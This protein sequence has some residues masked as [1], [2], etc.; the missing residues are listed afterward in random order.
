MISETGRRGSAA[1]IAT[2][3]TKENRSYLGS[4]LA[5]V[6]LLDL[7]PGLGVGGVIAL[8]PLE[9]VTASALL[10]ETHEGALKSLTGGRGDLVDL[11]VLH[12]VR[13]VDALEL[14]VA[15]DVG[16]EEKLD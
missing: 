5:G 15:S 3:S 7:A 13:A 4:A 16:D 8:D 11:L 14:E 10:K 1:L 2:E 9:E 12:D 6:T